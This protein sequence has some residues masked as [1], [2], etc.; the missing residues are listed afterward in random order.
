MI[1]HAITAQGILSTKI[2]SR[3]QDKIDDILFSWLEEGYRLH[4]DEKI[5][6]YC[7][8]LIS[9]ER[10]AFL[11]QL[12]DTEL[13]E[14]QNQILNIQTKIQ[15]SIIPELNISESMFYSS[16]RNEAQKAIEEFRKI[17]GTINTTIEQIINK[18]NDK[19]KNPFDP[20]IL[21]IELDADV[22]EI[23]QIIGKINSLIQANTTITQ[24]YSS[25]Q[26]AAVEEIEKLLV[27]SKYVGGNIP[28]LENSFKKATKYVKDVEMELTLVLCIKIVRHSMLWVHHVKSICISISFL[29]GI[30]VARVARREQYQ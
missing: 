26:I 13:Q 15:K 22:K 2:K 1:N 8:N 7:G 16:L 29:R 4:K 27:Y 14:L 5:C 10:Q 25:A 11:N 24:K 20:I 21:K 18:L 17:R 23:Q 30:L 6:R 12:F 3:V 19:Q 9:Q 28:P